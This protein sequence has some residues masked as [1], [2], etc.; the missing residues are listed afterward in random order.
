MFWVN[1]GA[2]GPT[3][4][5][6]LM[7]VTDT[8]RVPRRHLYLGVL[9][10]PDTLAIVVVAASR[11]AHEA[12]AEITAALTHLGVVTW[13]GDPAHYYWTHGDDHVD[14]PVVSS[15]LSDALLGPDW[16]SPL[17]GADFGLPAGEEPA[18]EADPDWGH[19]HEVDLEPS[20]SNDAEEEAPA[21]PATAPLDPVEEGDPPREEA[22]P[23]LDE[24]A[25]EPDGGED[26]EEWVG[27]A[28]GI[29]DKVA[30]ALSRRPEA[31]GETPSLHPWREGSRHPRGTIPH[32]GGSRQRAAPPPRWDSTHPPERNPKGNKDAQRARMGLSSSST[33]RGPDAPRAYPAPGSSDD[34]IRPLSIIIISEIRLQGLDLKKNHAP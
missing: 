33:A 9:F 14:E 6:E 10:A 5:Q 31:A 17:T 25:T 16:P 27:D 1:W 3:R 15:E 22:D 13:P 30:R 2:E 32:H 19:D 21:D 28:L 11:Q 4:E 26:G 29:Q 24:P 12:R 18:A 23:Q 7:R 8:G 34:E 20:E